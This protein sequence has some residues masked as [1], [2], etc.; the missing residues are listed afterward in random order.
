MPAALP[1][2]PSIVTRSKKSL[3]DEP[4]TATTF[5]VLKNVTSPNLLADKKKPDAKENKASP[6]PP[7]RPA[8][9]TRE[10][11]EPRAR[12]ERPERTE[13]TSPPRYNMFPTRDSAPPMPCAQYKTEKGYKCPNCHRCYNARRNLVRH[14]TLECG[15][16]PQYKCPYCS[17]KKHRRNELKK[18]LEKKHPNHEPKL[19]ARAD[20]V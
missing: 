17:Y 1:I 7:A 19:P 15:R 10:T 8:P 2:T 20:R 18:H 12:P 3:D 6:P 13:R 16:E 11:R 4:P 9:R 5:A 14:V